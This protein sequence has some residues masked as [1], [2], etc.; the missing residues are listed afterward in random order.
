MHLD[1]RH[2][3]YRF[4]NTLDFSQPIRICLIGPPAVGKS[5]IAKR[6]CSH[7]QI[8]HIT[9]KD[10]IDEK[11][12]QL[13]GGCKE[14]LV[15]QRWKIL[16]LHFVIFTLEFGRKRSSRGPTLRVLAKRWQLPRE[17][18]RT[19]TEAWNWMTVSLFLHWYDFFFSVV[20]LLGGTL[21]CSML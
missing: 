2:H 14:Q 7:Y 8:H 16:C 15:Q 10:I 18:R 13:V 5:T 4:C 1:C 20:S 11:F 17:H 9:V 12:A 3:H 21:S 19:W 6:L